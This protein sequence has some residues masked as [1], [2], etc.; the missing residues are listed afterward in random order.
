MYPKI[1]NWIYSFLNLSTS[2]AAN[3]WQHMYK[4]YCITLRRTTSH[5]R[6]CMRSHRNGSNE[7]IERFV[8]WISR[9]AESGPAKCCTSWTD[10][11]G[12]GLNLRYGS[13]KR[14][15]GTAG[16]EKRMRLEPT[17]MISTCSSVQGRRD[18]IECGYSGSTQARPTLMYVM[19]PESAE[20]INK[21]RY[22]VVESERAW[23]KE[24]KIQ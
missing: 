13:K 15:K 24:I 23:D 6:I 5:M 14:N 3:I 12:P 19:E 18:R 1:E 7:T 10:C 4:L 9:T 11:Y 17:G 8:I 2:H 22:S 16:A 21:N 20:I